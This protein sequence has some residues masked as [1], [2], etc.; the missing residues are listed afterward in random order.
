M[1]AA[2]RSFLDQ[3][4][5]I[6]VDCP[7]LSPFASVDLHIDL[8][9]AAYLDQ[10]KRYLHTSPEFGM[11]RLLAEGIGD[12]YQLS[13]VFR[14]GE[15]GS[16]HNPEFMMLEWYRM[17]MHFDEMIRETTDLVKVFLGE[18]PCE[19][20]TYREAF[21][22]YA[23]I[24]YLHATQRDLIELIKS[25]G[26]PVHDGIELDD[27]DTLLDI[28]LERRVE[29]QFDRSCVTIL[30][31]YP[32]S[33]SALSRTK[34]IGEESV[35]ERFEIY[36]KGLE[37]ANGYHELTDYKEQ[38]KRFERSNQQR[39]ALGKPQL[40]PDERL[41]EALKK[42]VPDCCG[43]A[44]GFDRLMMLRHETLSISDVLPFAWNEA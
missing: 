2:C 25:S 6:E 41:I 44:V 35:S 10:E 22:K 1:L 8:I 13:H 34:Q 9:P 7:A 29:P 30:K 20:I 21:K 33:Q 3:K 16:R 5:V 36:Y 23:G 43:V 27:K 39:F 15:C 40:P 28:I 32:A 37:L 24:D 14:D 17:G 38:A 19:E 4:G 12:I 26:E 31:Y 18:I 11:K 42:G